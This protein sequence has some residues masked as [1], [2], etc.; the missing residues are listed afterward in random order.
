MK[1][2]NAYDVAAYLFHQQMA[3]TRWIRWR[4]KSRPFVHRGDDGLSF[5]LHPPQLIDG[6]IFAEGIFERRLLRFLRRFLPRGRTM[7]DIGAN[8]GNHA[9][10]LSRNFE[11]VHCFEPNPVAVTRLTDNIRLN[12]VQNITVHPVGLGDVAAD[13]PFHENTSGNLGASSFARGN[14]DPSGTLPVVV[15]DAYLA[16][17]KIRSIDFIKVD[18]EGFEP[19]VLRGLSRTIAEHQPII[20]LEFD[21]TDTGVVRFDDIRSALPGYHFAEAVR[22]SPKRGAIARVLFV[23]ENG[24]EPDL[25][26]MSA[27]EPRFYDAILALPPSE[28]A[29]IRGRVR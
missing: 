29:L 15:G 20:V 16:E 2:R 12:G 13:L 26:E 8:V 5:R 3:R 14:C 11:T 4:Q 25:V 22:T 19:Q 17:H 9:I 1:L 23:L 28:A 27:P 6:Y 21:G 7:L 18:V 24:I 10:Y